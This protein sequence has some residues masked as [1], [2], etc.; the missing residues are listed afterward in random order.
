MPFGMDRISELDA[1][2]EK[3]DLNQHPFYK[4][5]KEGTLPR[6][7]LVDYSG[8]YGRFVAT[9]AQAW[10]TLGKP[11]YANDERFHETLWA[12]FQK[13]LG[14]SLL[15]NHPQTDALVQAATTLFAA[16]G[17]A[18]GALYAFEAQQPVTS[19]AKLEGLEAH[20]CLGDAGHEYFR[21]HA[22]D[23]REI[24]ELRG[25]VLELSDEDYARAKGACALLCAALWNALDG[26]YYA[27][28]AVTA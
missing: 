3:F 27:R 23:F 11:H 7:D 10:D 24:E 5:W 2:I 16:R 15:S 28:R 25:L 22:G 8:E 26:V 17:E 21:V 9:V 1:I 6:E 12:G 19:Q 20:Y 18:A 13:A 4:E 14:L